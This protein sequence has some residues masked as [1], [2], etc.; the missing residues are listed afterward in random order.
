VKVLALQGELGLDPALFKEELGTMAAALEDMID[1]GITPGNALAILRGALVADPKMEELATITA[2]MIDLHEAEATQANIMAVFRL[3]EEQVAAGLNRTLL[4]EEF[5]TIIAAKIDMMDAGIAAAS[6][7]A[8]LNSTLTADPTLE[9]LTT[10]T[11][12]MIDLVEKGLSP[13]EA[14]A[15]IRDAIRADPTLQNFDDLIELEPPEN[16]EQEPDRPQPG[17]TPTRSG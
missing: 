6:A 14:L 16:E 15:R 5:S 9:E 4:L 10:I 3:V 8:V 2:A 12:A 13:E 17:R 11:A 1:A 7:V